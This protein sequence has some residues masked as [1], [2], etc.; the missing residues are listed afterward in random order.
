MPVRRAAAAALPKGPG[1]NGGREAAPGSRGAEKREMGIA[2]YRGEGKRGRA[3]RAPRENGARRELRCPAAP[4]RRGPAPAPRA[5]PQRTERGAAGAPRGPA[6][7]RR[8]V[9]PR[10]AR[11][12]RERGQT[13]P[14]RSEGGITAN[15][16]KT[17]NKTKSFSE[18]NN[19]APSPT[20]TPETIGALLTFCG[21]EGSVPCAGH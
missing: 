9:R 18:G 3:E 6:E 10:R 4:A 12:R 21:R 20:L 13:E 15:R 19:S 8:R 17:E 14:G 5:E 11:R 16:N 1:G 7:G 2:A